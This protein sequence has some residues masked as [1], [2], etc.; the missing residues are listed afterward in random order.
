MPQVF[1]HGL[2][3]LPDDVLMRILESGYKATH[4]G[5]LVPIKLSHVCK[6]FRRVAL[7]TPLLWS[8]F[9]NAQREDEQE[10]MLRRAGAVDLTF[11]FN[12]NHA[13][14]GQ[15]AQPFN[16]FLQFFLSLAPRCKAFAYTQLGDFNDDD[17]LE[18]KELSRLTNGMSL[19][20][21]ESLTVHVW[22][23]DGFRTSDTTTGLSFYRTWKVPSL[24]EFIG[25]NAIPRFANT[26]NMESSEILFRDAR[27]RSLNLREFL[28]SI[29]AQRLP[30][31]QSL[32]LTLENVVHSNT[33]TPYPH[34]TL[35]SLTDLKVEFFDVQAAVATEIFAC[36][37][38]PVLNRLAVEFWTSEKEDTAAQIQAYIPAYQSCPVLQ[39]V[40]IEIRGS[41]R[42]DCNVLRPLLTRLPQVHNLDL[43]LPRYTSRQGIF[44]GFDRA[45]SVQTNLRTLKVTVNMFLD[46][47]S[48]PL[49][50]HLRSLSGTRKLDRIEINFL[51]DASDWKFEVRSGLKHLN[52]AENIKVTSNLV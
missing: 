48:D 29:Q 17:D 19:P 8:T 7:A 49:Q 47:D 4:D 16:K 38:L 20:R 43:S 30:L 37:T 44:G 28:Q 9:T 25:S 33:Q 12:N 1:K 52:V 22:G 31:L 40:A 23:K 2:D 32:S 10:E 45:P 18:Q 41:I 50:R 6:R 42:P 13:R 46:G 14:T 34:I 15:E 27:Y 11:L 51:C 5:R 36:L 21:L 35:S 24:K 39:N 26:V 3:K